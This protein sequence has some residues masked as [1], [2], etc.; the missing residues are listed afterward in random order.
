MVKLLSHSQVLPLWKLFCKEGRCCFVINSV[1]YIKIFSKTDMYY[2]TVYLYVKV[3]LWLLFAKNKTKTE[4]ILSTV[5]NNKSEWLF[6]NCIEFITIATIVHN[7]M[8]KQITVQSPTMLMNE[9]CMN[10][11]QCRILSFFLHCMFIVWNK[12]RPEKDLIV[13]QNH[14]SLLVLF[15]FVDCT[16]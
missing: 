13:Q 15:C 7:F 5:C 4:S 9:M 16:H 3:N 6:S 8:M 10:I 11:E 12:K 14:S 2:A 1:I